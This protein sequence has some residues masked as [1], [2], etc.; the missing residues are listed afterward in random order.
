MAFDEVQFPTNLS[1]GLVGGPAYQTDILQL[2]SGYEAR[3]QN[4]PVALAKFDASMAHW[5]AADIATVVAFFRARKGKARGF[6]F[7]DWSDYQ[8]T[9]E[10][11]SPAVGDGVITAFQMQ[12]TYT[13]G[14]ISEIRTITKPVLGT[15]TAYKNGVSAS[16]TIN[17]TT[18]VVTF[19]TAPGV[20][21]VPTATF[22]FDLPVRFD[23][24]DLKIEVEAPG[25]F[26]WGQIPIVEIRD[27]A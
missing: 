27:I 2:D 17:Y 18:G 19:S 15:V 22:E 9:A 14:G 25:V 21:V 6:R 24:D 7:K 16:A 1:W 12:K 4:W 26:S 3:N 10:V 13:S 23:V 5:T 11:M 20:G 8:G